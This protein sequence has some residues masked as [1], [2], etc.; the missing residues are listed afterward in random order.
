[1]TYLD[2]DAIR[3]HRLHNRLQAVLII[4]GMALLL[5]LCGELLLGEGAFLWLAL[6]TG[7]TLLLT[8]QIP[9]RAVMRLYR[10]RPIERWELPELA[11]MIETLAARARLPAVPQLYYVPSATL[12]AFT[13]GNRENAAVA[14]TDGLLRGLDARELAGVLAHEVSHIAHHDIRVM[15]LADTVSRLTGLMAG[16]GLLL[17]LVGL[18]LWLLGLA[19][20]SLSGLALLLFAPTLAALL[21]AALSRSREFEAD[22]GA[23]ELTGDPQG[24]ASALARL[25]YPAWSGWRRI[26][27]PRG[28]ESAPSSLRS[29]PST[30]ERIRRLLELAPRRRV[31][32]FSFASPSRRLPPDFIVVTRRPRHH[33]SGLWY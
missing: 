2:P 19:E 30:E 16:L 21:Q 33:W 28:R 26:F 23:A 24:L 22:L 10:A 1:M 25:E 31:E 7:A 27:A 5:G 20:I 15:G 29:H 32:P 13:V 14:V 12:N 6:I 3:D 18:P 9:P 11:A 17:T 8:P 4:G